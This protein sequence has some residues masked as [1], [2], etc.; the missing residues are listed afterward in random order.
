MTERARRRGVRTRKGA[1][2]RFFAW[3]RDELVALVPLSLRPKNRPASAQLWLTEEAHELVFWRL[4]GTRL[5]EQGRLA[6]TESS[7]EAMQLAFNTLWARLGKKPIGLCLRRD[8]VLRTQLTFPIAA[9]NNLAQA[10]E[11]DLP[12]KTPFAANQAY[13]DYELQREDLKAGQLHINLTVVP[14]AQVD[15]L[16]ARLGEWGVHTN[17]IMVDEDLTAGRH[18]VDLLPLERRPKSAPVWGWI[19]A[20]MAVVTLALLL[21]ALGL[22]LWQKRAQ[23]IALQPLEAK[24]SAEANVVTRLRDEH[25]SLLAIYNFPLEKKYGFPP[26]VGLLEEVTRLLPDDTWLQQL[27]LRGDKVLMQG[28]SRSP[29]RLIGLF[30]KSRLLGDANFKSPL[31]KARE[32]EERFQLEATVRP[33]SVADVL[34]ER[35]AEAEAQK[36]ATKPRHGRASRQAPTST[37][38]QP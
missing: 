18:C 4:A 30:E 36:K 9:R 28:S 8:D 7:S 26:V 11:F 3:W 34:A 25:D 12:R 2:S 23:L 13:F 33:V 22:P 5:E 15:R 6:L 20:G 24:A 31:V 21:A 14:R 19:Y 27:E 1:L 17:A 37:G 32:G 10:L 29:A 35:K 16:I 38:A